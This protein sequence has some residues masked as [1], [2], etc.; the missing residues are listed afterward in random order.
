MQVW[1]LFGILFGYC[2]AIFLC[3]FIDCNQNG[4]GR[5][6]DGY[7]EIDQDWIQPENSDILYHFADQ[8]NAMNWYEANDYCLDKGGYLAEPQTNEENEFLKNHVKTNFDNTNWW[9]GAREGENCKCSSNDGRS[10]GFD[11]TIDYKT[12][13]G[14][15]G[16]NGFVQT[17][18]PRRYQKNC[19]GN[20]W[21]WSLSGTKLEFQ[22]W[23]GQSGEPNG[24]TEHCSALWLKGDFK[25]S[26]WLCQTTT[27]NDH[28]FK[29]ICQKD[30]NDYDD[31]KR[32][33]LE[34]K[35]ECFDRGVTYKSAG[36]DKLE[37]ING[38]ESAKICQQLCRSNNQ[39]NYWTWLQKRR[40][41]TKCRLKSGILRSRFRREKL[42]AVS[43][44]L[45]NND[46][47]SNLIIEPRNKN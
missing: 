38:V 10:N 33:I 23:N 35:T 26:D 34:D 19:F 32:E 25:W 12:L 36:R 28:L 2:D 18:C 43:G 47:D 1:F 5:S 6:N 8:E 44:S 27:D 24:E 20:I 13:T 37:T 29:P 42:N 46:C 14:Q 31:D 39:C 45:L 40:G 22:D 17:K 41:N 7:I 16:S 9:I 11:A 21:L 3:L 30:L 15:K 4:S